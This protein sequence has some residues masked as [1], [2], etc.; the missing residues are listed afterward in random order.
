MKS[1]ILTGAL[2]SAV[3]CSSVIASDFNDCQIVTLVLGYDDRNGHIKLDCP[4]S[5][6]PGCGSTDGSAFV[7]FDRSTDAGKQTLALTMAAYMSGSK[8]SGNIDHAADSC[9][10][11]QTNVSRMVSIYLSK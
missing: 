11:W 1:V 2:L 5:N 7:A 3:F 10:S 9:P 8:I 6:Q 4:I